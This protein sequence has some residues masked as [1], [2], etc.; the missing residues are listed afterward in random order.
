VSSIIFKNCPACGS[1]MIERLNESGKTRSALCVN[2][3]CRV[4]CLTECAD[5]RDESAEDTYHLRKLTPK[6]EYVRMTVM[7]GV[8]QRN[9]VPEK[10]EKQWCKEF[11]KEVEPPALP[12]KEHK[13]KVK[14]VKLK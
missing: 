2:Y 5:H 11:K 9:R 12:I 13:I 4:F 1:M 10:Y 3:G 14:K 7:S 6:E 8:K